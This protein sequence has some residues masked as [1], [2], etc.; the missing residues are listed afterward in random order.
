MPL[1]FGV[2]A[3]GETIF[4]SS[5]T[6]LLVPRSKRS[7]TMS[8]EQFARWYGTTFNSFIMSYVQTTLP[9][10]LARTTRQPGVT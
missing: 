2:I 10:G 3:A 4:P 7:P 8:G 1:R 5:L 6:P 9:S